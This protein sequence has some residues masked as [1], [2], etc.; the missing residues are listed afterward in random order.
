ML[1]L[2]LANFA[3]G[4]L[5]VITSALTNVSGEAKGHQQLWNFGPD[6]ASRSFAVGSQWALLHQPVAGGGWS[7]TMFAKT[8]AMTS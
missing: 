6:D 5:V 3:R 2:F 7:R 1:M 4:L 8:F